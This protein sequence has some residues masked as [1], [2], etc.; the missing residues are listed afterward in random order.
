VSARLAAIVVYFRTPACLAACLDGLRRQTSPP[1]EIVVV[2]NSSALDGV[3]QRPAAG[4]DWRWVRA[5]RNVGFGAACNLGAGATMSDHLLF[6]NADVVAGDTACERLRSS[7]DEDS[8][9]AVVGPRIYGADG[10]VELS[11]RAFP[12]PATGL[13]GRSSLLTKLLSGINRTPSGVSPALGSSGYVDWVSGAC[14]LVRRRAF[15]EVGGFD[16]DYWMYWEDAD[17]CRRLK[18]RGWRTMLQTDAEVAHST[19]SSGRT[20]QTIEAFHLSAAR[21]YERHIARSRRAAAVAR[22]L[23]LVRMRMM[24]RRHARSPTS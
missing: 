24:L 14:M 12:T 8:M 23:L 17:L 3:E 2:D 5:E 22:S 19:G 1:D 20:E 13:L 9:I 7:A 4:D 18:Q 10:T 6:M 16:E 15:E 11:A 21:Y